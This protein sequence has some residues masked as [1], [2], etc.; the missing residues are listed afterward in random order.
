MR[1]VEDDLSGDQITR[2]L[3][4][5][6]DSMIRHSPAGSVHAL[7][8]DGLRAH[9]VTF[10]CAWQGDLLL[11]CCALREIDA[12]HGELKS[13][14]TAEEHR[15]KGVARAMLQ[16]VVDECCSRGYTRLS[17]ETGSGDAFLAADQLYRTFGFDYCGPFGEYDPD[18]FS[19][20]MT[21]QLQDRQPTRR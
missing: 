14:R 1:I 17:L 7:G 19:R 8:L 6:L 3:G 4:E 12:T 15:R 16:H 11:G 10:W 18:P 9:D 21:L 2:L 5:H 20:F 13:M